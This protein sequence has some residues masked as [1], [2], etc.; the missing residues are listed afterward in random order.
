MRIL[1]LVR[2]AVLSLI[3]MVALV[4]CLLREPYVTQE[5]TPYRVTV[6]HSGAIKTAHYLLPE[7][8]EV[9]SATSHISTFIE[10]D[11]TQS[12]DR[13]DW[14]PLSPLATENSSI[15]RLRELYAEPYRTNKLETTVQGVE[16][17][18]ITFIKAVG[19]PG[20]PINTAEVSL[21]VTVRYL[22]AES[23]WLERTGVILNKDYSVPV[24]LTLFK[25]NDKWKVHL[26]YYSRYPVYGPTGS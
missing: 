18:H 14:G 26:A 24:K 13:L 9:K 25:E 19:L 22:Q 4:G 12:W 10:K 20:T 3:P 15:N 21:D 8:E 5:P 1:K 23:N 16:I 7:H 6:V 11:L 2:V 17:N